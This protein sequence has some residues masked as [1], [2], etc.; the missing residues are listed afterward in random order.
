MID[1]RVCFDTTSASKLRNNLEYKDKLIDQKSD[2]ICDLIEKNKIQELNNE[3]CKEK[4]VNKNVGLWIT[5][6]LNFL[7][8]IAISIIANSNN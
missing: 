2:S 6:G 7:A 1:G 3:K 4:L 5:S 8:T